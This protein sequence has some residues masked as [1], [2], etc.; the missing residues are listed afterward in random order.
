MLLLFA[1]LALAQ[2]VD[3]D[4]ELVHPTFAPGALPGVD[5]AAPTASGAVH[6]GLSTQY[7]L[8][9]VVLYQSGEPA[10]AVVHQRLAGRLGVE[11]GVADFLALR[12]GMPAY[13]QW[14]SEIPDYARDG[15]VAGDLA[16]GARVSA[17]ALGPVRTGARLDLHTPTSAAGAWAGERGVR[18]QP[19]LLVGVDAG[20][21]DALVDASA[22]LRPGVATLA[23]FSLGPELALGVG[24]RYAVVEDRVAPWLAVLGRLPLDPA[25][26][27][28]GSGGVEAL[29]GV[30][31]AP[32]EGLGLDVLVGK[33]LADGYGTSRVR[34]GLALT[35]SRVPEPAPEPVVVAAPPPPPRVELKDEE[36]EEIL[37]DRP[38]AEPVPVA[39]PAAR[40]V[41]QQIVIR[42]PIQFERGTDRILPES[43]P[44]L[45]AVAAL[46]AEHPELLSVVIEGHASDEG[47]YAYN[48][49]LSVRRSLAVFRALVEAG[50]HPDRLACRAWGEVAPAR[51]GESEDAL[52][53]NRRVIFHIARQWVPGEPY[54]GWGT[55]IRL[56]WTGDARTLAP[57]PADFGKPPPPPPPPERRRRDDDVDPRIFEPDG[58]E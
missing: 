45:R 40:I 28:Q 50:V 43:D 56:P 30:R 39:A 42:D 22:V 34:A 57:P 29:A 35:W 27:G 8:D 32:A 36:V 6:L 3:A 58:E 55:D 17:W 37:R 18:A 25:R 49:E 47:D 31:L 12:V 51:A 1:P 21:F 33:G 26:F 19:G 41:A 24:G 16:L 46:M 2:G 9:P 5:S 4:V 20:R 38:D 48:Y 15:A 54:P 23:D 44:T 7:V 11:L 10:G 53:A 14:G 13:A 52:A